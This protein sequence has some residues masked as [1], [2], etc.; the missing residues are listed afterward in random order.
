MAEVREYKCPC[1]SGKLEFDS[2]VQKMKCP[3]CDSEFDVETVQNYN[4]EIDSAGE[5]EMELEAPTG[6]EWED[7][8]TDGMKVYSCKSCGGE[9]IADETTGATHCPYCGNPV[10]MSGQFSGDIRPDLVIPFKLDKEAAKTALSKHL[11]GKKLLPKVFREQNHI[12]E[13]KGLYVPVWLFSADADAHMVFR[14]EK[15]RSWQDNNFS[16]VETS[17]YS[18]VRAGN[19]SFEDVPV[20]GSEKMPD[21]LMESIEPFDVSKAETFS[22]AFLSGYLADRYDVDAEQSIGRANERI[23]KSTEQAFAG[24]VTG[25]DSVSCENS[26][27]KLQNSRSKYALYPVW[28]LNTTWNE[29]KYTFAMNG[30]TGKFVGDLPADMGKFYGY[31]CGSFA[32]ALAIMLLGVFL[33]TGVLDSTGVIVSLVVAGIVAAVTGGSLKAQLKTVRRAYGAA[34]YQKPDSMNLT[35]RN[36]NFLTKKINR[37][38]INRQPPPGSGGGGGNGGGLQVV[39]RPQQHISANRPGNMNRPG[40]M[41]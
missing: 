6:S 35:Q 33:F 20:D 34:V 15:V 27:V 16:Y 30:Q 21:E 32:I 23:K 41:R 5:D 28:I 18:A 25:Y 31:L 13:I 2:A 40:G 10:V 26:A 11:E 39:G 36:D 17:Y 19:I 37:T 9:I 7:G 4:D 12:D 3:Y 29:Q 14:G 38:P 22:T 1:C 8:E 24:T